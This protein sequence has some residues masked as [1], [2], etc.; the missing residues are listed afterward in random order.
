MTDKEE[1]E[2]NL[3]GNNPACR[4]ASRQVPDKQYWQL[5]RFIQEGVSINIHTRT[6]WRGEEEGRQEIV[7]H[8]NNRNP[9]LCN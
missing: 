5:P 2:V 9:G 8:S 3:A 4:Q 7:G 6:E 1:V